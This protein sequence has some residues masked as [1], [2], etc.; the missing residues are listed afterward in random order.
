MKIISEN[1][2]AYFDYEILDR[3]EAGVEL[4]GF[5]VKSAKNGRFNI[6]GSY[7]ILRG[8]EAWL[9]NSDIPP[10]QPKNTPPDYDSKRNRRL[11]LNR[12]EIKFL[13]GK[14]QEKGLTLL[15]LKIYIKNNLIKLELGLA[16]H[17]KEYDK[18]ET[19]KKREA[20][21]KIRA[22]LKRE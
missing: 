14:L 13:S 15:P 6:A 9:I 4:R 8:G 22:T 10:Y 18:R 17:K 11:L 1:K 12:K 3:Y 16:R 20:S 21:K 7:V 19:I 5:E 2:K